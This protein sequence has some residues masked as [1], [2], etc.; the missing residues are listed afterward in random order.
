MSG[1]LLNSGLETW[2]AMRFGDWN[3]G[4]GNALLGADVSGVGR[5]AGSVW[6][7]GLRDFIK[8]LD[9]RWRK[10]THPVAVDASKWLADFW[11]GTY[12]VFV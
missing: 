12:R 11:S 9:S 3:G 8:W 2:Y 1:H 5:S 10:R 7:Y 6:K 4:D